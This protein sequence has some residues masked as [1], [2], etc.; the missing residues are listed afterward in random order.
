MLPINSLEGVSF[1]GVQLPFPTP[2]VICD[3]FFKKTPN[4]VAALACL[5]WIDKRI[6]R[7]L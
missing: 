1:K 7:I 5:S 2:H 6:L 3:F 4:T